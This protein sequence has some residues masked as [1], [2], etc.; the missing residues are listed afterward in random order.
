MHYR[1][2]VAELLVLCT[3]EHDWDVRVAGVATLLRDVTAA[4]VLDAATI[5]RVDGAVAT[6]LRHEPEVDDRLLAELLAA[7]LR[8]VTAQL[9]VQSELALCREALGSMPWLAIKGPVLARHYYSRP[10]IRAY[11]DLDLLVHPHQLGDALVALEGAGFRI[12]DRNWSLMT[13]LLVG[14]VHLATP[15][16][17]VLDLHW[18]LINDRDTREAFGIRTGELLAHRRWVSLGGSHTPTLGAVDTLLHVAMH[19]LRSGGD[20]LIWLKD[21][22]QIVL[23]EPPDWPALTLAAEQQGLLLPMAVMLSRTRLVL[24][25]EF[26]GLEG[27]LGPGGR[28]WSSL[29]RAVD[30]TYSP[31]RRGVGGSLTRMLSRSTR[32]TGRQTVV[33]LG[34]RFRTWSQDRGALL[35]QQPG[36]NPAA[37]LVD[38]GGAAGRTAYLRAVQAAGAG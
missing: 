15:L 12:L 31:A 13:D 16:G 3:R 9:R 10:A 18:D 29:L 26:P 8:H 6:V 37:L 5:H 27:H 21:L 17:G 38:S 22:E 33:E 4:E 11:S 19:A 24:G 34:R 28:L 36:L 23:R 32:S 7:A 20:R 1:R 25:L 2:Q 30:G 14:E 35:P